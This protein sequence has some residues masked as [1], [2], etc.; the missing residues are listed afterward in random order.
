MIGTRLYFILSVVLPNDGRT[1]GWFIYA[2]S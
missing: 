2:L 1:F